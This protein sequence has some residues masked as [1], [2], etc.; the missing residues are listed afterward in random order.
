MKYGA[1]DYQPE[2]RRRY[3]LCRVSRDGRMIP[4]F[5]LNTQ[6][7]IWHGDSHV[8]GVGVD[9]KIYM[10]ADPAAWQTWAWQLWR[11]NGQINTPGVSG[12]SYSLRIDK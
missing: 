9:G 6:G 11:M 10:Y 3:I 8:G 2:D 12:L 4:H 1:L 7:S 5:R